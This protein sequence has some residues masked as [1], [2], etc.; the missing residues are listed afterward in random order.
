MTVL[1]SILY[2]RVPPPMRNPTA[3]PSMFR[4]G[5][6]EENKML[7][8]DVSKSKLASSLV[9]PKS[10]L[11]ISSS[12][13][14]NDATGVDSLLSSIDPKIAW[15]VEPTGRYSA[16]VVKQATEAGRRV[17]LAPPR[18]AKLFLKSNN[19]RAK[20]DK[21][22][23]RGLAL[24]GL[25]RPLKPFPQKSENV[26][27]LDQLLS[28]RKGLSRARSSLTQQKNELP[29]AADALTKAINAVH[30]QIGQLDKAIHKQVT[31][32]PEFSLVNTLMQI[33]GVGELTAAAVAS[34]LVS[35]AFP[36]PDA[37][38]A[39]VGLDVGV[40]NSGKS[41]GR[42]KLSKQG[43]AELRRL[44]YISALA[45]LRCKKSVFK[46]R[47]NQEIA[48]GRKPTAALNIIAR[49]IAHICWALQK[50]PGPFD[51]SRVYRGQ[52]SV[53]GNQNLDNQQE[54]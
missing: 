1:L 35:K 33:P 54:D 11:A 16:L 32:H 6:G 19:P 9:D 42:V 50:H 34:R 20:T 8:I 31:I 2:I 36:T 5:V 44:L 21:I 13:I 15:V 40:R 18:A 41:I 7:G 51:A 48:R 30:E 14:T 23:G 4:K 37:F 12:V 43:D 29:Y 10:L 45:N 24:F 53:S 25:S 52:Q 47:Y 28:A 49:K 26:E 22:D 17:L 3:R 38:V 46:D 27:H 39:Y